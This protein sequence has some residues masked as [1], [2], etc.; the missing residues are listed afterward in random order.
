V[1]NNN[2]SLSLCKMVADTQMI[3]KPFLLQQVISQCLRTAL[4]CCDSM[5]FKMSDLRGWRRAKSYY[6]T[7]ASQIL[8]TLQSPHH[9]RMVLGMPMLSLISREVE[10][11][12][13]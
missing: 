13:S 10:D 11:G 6:S 5:N 4:R 12:A 2:V 1:E 9:W 8:P 7:S 3:I